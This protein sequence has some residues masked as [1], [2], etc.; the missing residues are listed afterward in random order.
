MRSLLP[1][2]VTVI[3]SKSLLRI[4]YAQEALLMAHKLNPGKLSEVQTASCGN[5]YLQSAPASLFN[6][7]TADKV[8][9]VLKRVRLVCC[10]P[11][12]LLIDTVY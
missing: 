8:G 4:P 7:R 5:I 11:L 9:K 3:H 12:I 1:H 10:S 2:A 6:M